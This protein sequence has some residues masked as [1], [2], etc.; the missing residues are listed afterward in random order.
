MVRPDGVVL[1]QVL[2][3]LGDELRVVG[4][5]LVEPEHHVGTREAAAQHREAHPVAHRRV[6]HLA[7]APDVARLDL[8]RQDA[9]PARFTTRTVPSTGISNVL[10]CEPYSSA[11][12]AMRPTL[13]TEPIVAGIERAV[14][15]AVV[16]RPRRTHPA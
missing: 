15:L 7:G 9:S 13:G 6:L 5:G 14:G 11:F 1:G 2:A 12:C 8:V 3:H 4:T 10:S 16:A